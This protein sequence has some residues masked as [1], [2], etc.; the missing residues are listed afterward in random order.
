MKK[1]ITTLAFIALT[2]I[3]AKALELPSLGIF[4]LTGGVAANQSVFGATAQ[5]D[6]YNMLGTS[7]DA[8]NKESGAF[9]DSYQSQFVEL[10]I[11]KWVSVGYE[12]V[13]GAI[14]TPQNINDHGSPGTASTPATSTVSVDFNDLETTYLKIN[15]P[16]LTGFY[17]TAGK[18]STDVDIKETQRSGNK[19]ANVNVDGTSTGAGYERFLG[20]SGFSIRAEAQYIELDNI[21]VNNGVTKTAGT[22]ANGGFNEI[23]A[24]NLEGLS[25]KVAI[26]YTL[27]RNN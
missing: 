15:L 19:Y 27:G 10:G 5:Q 3:S 20:D 1:I 24:T 6:E 22:T 23:K 2:T 25:G 9:A 26:S 21:T 4:S 7:I 18:L 13:D 8:T 16:I 12:M 14:S 11:G 17:V